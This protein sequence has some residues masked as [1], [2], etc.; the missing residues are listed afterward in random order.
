MNIDDDIVEAKNVPALAEKMQ[1]GTVYFEGQWAFY[2]TRPGKW[3]YRVLA[4]I[5]RADPHWYGH[6]SYKLG[7]GGGRAALMGKIN[8]DMGRKMWG[9]STELVSSE[10][11]CVKLIGETAQ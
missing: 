6:R 4:A 8:R 2:M 1:A 3:I 9:H 10:Q 7:Q 11:K 5:A